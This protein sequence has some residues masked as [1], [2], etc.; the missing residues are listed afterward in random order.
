MAFSHQKVYGNVYGGGEVGR[1][2]DD[3]KVT[4]GSATGSDAL[5]ITGSVFGAGAGLETHG[6]SALVRGNSAVTVQGIA[7]VGGSVYGG[8]E[9]ASVGR[10]S[11]D[12]NNLP[13]EPVSGGTCT[14]AVKDQVEITGDVFGAC[15]GVSPSASFA[16]GS[17]DFKCMKPYGSAENHPGGTVDTAWNYYEDDNTYVW[18]YFAD[19]AAYLNFLKTLALTSNT[20]TTISGTASVNGSVYGGGEVGI[21]LGGTDV[22]IAGGTVNHDV[23]GGGALAD[24]NYGMWDAENGIRKPYVKLSQLIVG[25]SAIGYYT[26]PN[27]ATTLITATSPNNT[28]QAGTD[29]Y[30]I[31]KTN[32]NLKGGTV[33]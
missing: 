16:N 31:Y 30:A 10:F 13:K 27:D 12:S 19:K 24:T 2:G 15:K 20:H 17:H 28:V 7:R 29:Y 32:V 1:L 22:N 6:Y 33:C 14:V 4:I 9:T 18:E 5:T 8:G 3:T 11:L 23:Y 25:S 21:T 26:S